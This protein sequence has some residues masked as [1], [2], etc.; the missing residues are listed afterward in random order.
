MKFESVRKVIV[1][2]RPALVSLVA[3]G[4]VRTAW[5]YYLSSLI[6]ESYS[7]SIAVPAIINNE[8]EKYVADVTSRFIDAL[9]HT[10]LNTSSLSMPA[11]TWTFTCIGFFAIWMYLNGRN[12]IR[13]NFAIGLTFLLTTAGYI[14]VILNSYLTHFVAE[15]ALVLS[16]F[17]RYISTWYQGIF[18]AIIVLILSEFNFE[19]YFKDNL[20]ANPN[21]RLQNNKM[22]V[23]V[24][25]IT[26]MALS[27]LSNIGHYVDLLRSPQNKG[28]VVREG[29]APMVQ[30]INAAKVPDGSKVY[31]I[32]QHTV[33]FEYFV[34]RYEMI[35][36]QFGKNAF[37]IGSKWGEDDIWTDPT[38]DAEKWSKTLRDYDFVVLYNTTDLF[39]EEFSS[40]F[41]SGVG[42]PNSVYKIKKLANS[43]VLS[44][45]K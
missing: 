45:V 13:K 42:E 2:F 7:W 21:L 3:V 1:Q 15:E 36:A 14:A 30:A 6:S 43:V 11:S 12:N 38:M 24:L 34:I 8:G 5:D 32:T 19:D 33:G 35:G 16:S 4:T 44:K 22:R 23:S 27:T 41:E 26:F 37:S 29:F 39:N 10:N 9:F 28:S 25:L 18:F 40:L 17:Q 20:S 31:V